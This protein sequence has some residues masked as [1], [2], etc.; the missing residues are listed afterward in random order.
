MIAR[1]IVLARRPVGTP[2][3]GDF[4]IVEAAVPTPGDGEILVRNA[5]FALDAATRGFLDDRPSY[6]PPVAI[7]EAVRS[8]ALG[9]VVASRNT[10]FAPGE[11]VRALVAWEEYSLIT[12]D[13]LGLE[14]VV[15]SPGTPLT[16]YMGT[17]G[18]SG[19]TAY[20]GLHGVGRAQPGE[21]VVVS[22]AAG[23][24]G[25]IVGQ[26]ARAHGCRVVGIVG[27]DAKARICAELGFEATVN[28][29][30]PG[31]LGEQL[32]RALPNGSDVFFDGV[33]G[34]VLDAMLPLMSDFGRIVVCGMIANYNRADDQYKIGNIWQVLVKRIRMQGFL[35]FDY[36]DLVSEAQ[37]VLTRMV[38]NR[39]LRPLENVTY[40]IENTPD[41]FIRLMAGAT[42]GKTIVDLRAGSRP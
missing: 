12:P 31:G 37:Q 36:P 17:L 5:V 26:I 25:N 20:V 30:E 3:S 7:G 41:A 16:H 10:G 8:M 40:G 42:I 35:T 19:L 38:I 23:A 15:V 28:Y 4:A 32:Q 21:T 33:G 27:S 1:K 39:Q 34:P 11:I 2:Q 18:P 24:V 22:A 6:L 9:E 29:R 13:A 14:K